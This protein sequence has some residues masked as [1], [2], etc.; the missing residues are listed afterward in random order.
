MCA[1]TT[2]S[3]RADAVL[4]RIHQP[5]LETGYWRYAAFAFNP[6]LGISKILI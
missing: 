5:E 4:G 3:A 2:V 6:G 1:K